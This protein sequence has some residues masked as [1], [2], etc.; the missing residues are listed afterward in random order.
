VEALSE[1]P[2]TGSG[3]V[4]RLHGD[5][6]GSWSRRLHKK[7]RIIDNINESVATVQVFSFRGHDADS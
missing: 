4:E 2:T 3:S 5:F 6:A 1:H 7:D